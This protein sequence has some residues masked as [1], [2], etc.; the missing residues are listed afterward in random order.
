MASH[1]QPYD[2]KIE[3]GHFQELF[4]QSLGYVCGY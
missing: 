4:A 2:G 3:S 1:K